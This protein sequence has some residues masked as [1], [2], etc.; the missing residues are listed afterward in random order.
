[1]RSDTSVA[2]P[3][4]QTA[5]S[6]RVTPFVNHTSRS[7]IQAFHFDGIRPA[8]LRLLV[9]SSSFSCVSSVE[10]MHVLEATRPHPCTR[11]VS[12]EIRI[13]GL[14]RAAD[15][16]QQMK[17]FALSTKGTQPCAV[18][19]FRYSAVADRQSGLS[20]IR[21]ARFQECQSSSPD[22][23]NTGDRGASVLKWHLRCGLQESI[24]WEKD[25]S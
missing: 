19:E 10:C 5:R 23:L 1:L 12:H 9:R 16:K 11:A 17:E 2:V 25:C 22:R 13:G 24:H 18:F 14:R 6:Y 15:A 7:C 21:N 20:S 4:G 8:W 3:S